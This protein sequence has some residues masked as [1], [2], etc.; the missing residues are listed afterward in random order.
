MDFLVKFEAITHNILAL[1]NQESQ[2]HGVSHFEQQIIARTHVQI[3]DASLLKMLSKFLILH[4]PKHH[5]V[6]LGCQQNFPLLLEHNLASFI[7]EGAD[8]LG[9][10]KYVIAAIAEVIFAFEV[11]LNLMFV[12]C[13]CHDVD[14]NS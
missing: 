14:R 4:F 12:F 10:E 1:L 5:S 13:A 8:M 3:F 11:G 9:E 6:P 2:T 7:E